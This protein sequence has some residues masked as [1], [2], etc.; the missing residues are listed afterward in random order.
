MRDNPPSRQLDELKTFLFMYILL[1]PLLAAL[2][3]D[4]IDNIFAACALFVTMT[5]SAF[6]WFK[7]RLQALE[8]S[9]K[10]LERQVED[11]ESLVNDEI[12]GPDV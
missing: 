8:Q 5:G 9:V 4:K 10:E 7:K 3:A 1:G 11:A 12:A 2:F 6:F